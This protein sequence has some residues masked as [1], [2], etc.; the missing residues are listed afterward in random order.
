MHA[1]SR[2]SASSGMWSTLKLEW[3]AGLRRLPFFT[4]RLAVALLGL[5]VV[6]LAL[7]GA[8]VILWSG[9]QRSELPLGP[10]PERGYPTER[11]SG[12]GAGPADP[13]QVH[14]GAAVPASAQSSSSSSSSRPTS[15]A[16]STSSRAAP[17]PRRA[18]TP[19]TTP[20]TTTTTTTT[21]T[22]ST[23]GRELVPPLT[24]P[25]EVGALLP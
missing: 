11:P 17:G 4:Q 13:P 7:V 3:E 9:P 24:V 8:M 19:S 16:T 10:P 1:R 23:T 5:L 20:T 2:R 15:G 6:S 25:P 22:P 18:A 14:G 21:T 12:R